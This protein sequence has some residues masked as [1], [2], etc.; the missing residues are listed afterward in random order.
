MLTGSIT[1]SLSCNKQATTPNVGNS[2][3]VVDQEDRCFGLLMM[4]VIN[5]IYLF[6]F[7]LCPRSCSTQSCVFSS[8]LH[9]YAEFGSN[10]TLQK[11]KLKYREIKQTDQGKLVSRELRLY[12]SVFILSASL[13]VV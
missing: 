2:H 9:N 10:P 7:L 5:N 11:S 6:I 3:I 13:K 1:N 4:M 8:H 12:T